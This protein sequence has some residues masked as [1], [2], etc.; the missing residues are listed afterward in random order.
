MRR[1]RVI[2]DPDD[3]QRDKAPYWAA[4]LVIALHANDRVRVDKA[5][6]ALERLGIDVTFK[7]KAR[8]FEG[9]EHA[10]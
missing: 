9:V 7:P 2:P 8:H 3:T 6:R 4:A 1:K 10:G 5:R